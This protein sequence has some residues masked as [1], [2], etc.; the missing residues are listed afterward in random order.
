[1]NSVERFWAK[2]DKSGECWEWTGGL[3]NHGYGGFGLVATR[4]N[5]KIVKSHRLSY[6]LHH[7]LTIDLLEHPDI[8][9]CHRCD[10]P[11]C[12]NPSHLFLGSQGDNARDRDMKGRGK[13]PRVKGEINGNSKLTEEQVREIRGRYAKGNITQKALSDE[14]DVNITAI[15]KIVRRLIWKH[16]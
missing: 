1:M 3:D 13:P 14:Y 10:N 15:N 8:C 16:I 4:L 11:K 5:K 2:V 12:V 6:V 7:P 9:V